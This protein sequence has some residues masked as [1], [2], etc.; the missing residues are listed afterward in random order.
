[1][2]QSQL[3]TVVIPSL[4]QGRFLNQAL[5]SIFITN[6]PI[7][8]FVMDGGSTDGSIQVIKKW[9]S[10]LAGWRSCKDLGQASAINEGVALGSAP[11]L[12]W[13]NSDDY[14][15][16]GGLDNLYSQILNYPLAPVVYGNVWNVDW[17]SNVRNKVRVEPFD[18]A[19]LALRC[20]IS[21]P[22]SLIRRS[23]WESVN[24]L[25]ET[26]HM[27]MDYDLWWRLYIK[28]GPL[29]HF[30]CFVAVNREHSGAKT[31][32]FRGRHYSEAISIVRKYNNYL[33][34]KWWLFMPYSVWFKSLMAKIYIFD[35]WFRKRKFLN[36]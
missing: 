23:M 24:G 18:S 26:L 17:K 12:C 30:D 31:F 29:V 36:E 16:P 32:N 5:E 19:R 15:L 35:E 25:D 4:N 10:R 9:E 8:V 33:P 11:Y 13:L 28:F 14:F 1:M 7:E 6:L 2:S 3:I 21:Q 34:L 22:G 27:A 20:L